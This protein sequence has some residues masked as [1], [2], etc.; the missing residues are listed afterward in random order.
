MRKEQT[1]AP[2][3]RTFDDAGLQVTLNETGAILDVGEYNIF[4]SPTSAV[5][6]QQMAKAFDLIKRRMLKRMYYLE[7]QEERE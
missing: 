2:Q 6:A 7:Q 3:T 4:F 5:Q 1:P